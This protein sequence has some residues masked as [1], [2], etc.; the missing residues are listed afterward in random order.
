[1][2][3][4]TARALRIMKERRMHEKSLVIPSREEPQDAR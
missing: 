2:T 1:M 3:F 4:D